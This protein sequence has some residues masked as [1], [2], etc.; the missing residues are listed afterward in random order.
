MSTK[1]RLDFIDLHKGIVLLIMIEVHVFNSLLLTGIKDA[2]WF[3]VINFINGLVAPSFIFVSGFAFSLSNSQKIA[4]LK[5]FRKT[6]GKYISRLLLIFAAGYSLHLP[7]FS[8]KKTIYESTPEQIQAFLAVD[9]LQS[10]AVGLF[11]LFLIRIIFENP[12]A[13]K[14]ALFSLIIIVLTLSVVFWNTEITSSLPLF[15]SNYLTNINGSQ[16]PL[17]PWFAFM[18]AGYISGI[19]FVETRNSGKVETYFKVVYILAGLFIVNGHLGIWDN[20][21]LY[22]PL[23]RPNFF[24]FILRLGYIFLLFNLCR[25]LTSKINLQNSFILNISRASLLVY[26]LHLI[27]MFGMFWNGESLVFI[28]GNTLTLMEAIGATIILI[29]LMVTIAN[30]WTKLK[31]KNPELSGKITFSFALLIALIYIIR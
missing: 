13:L 25:T 5:K 6:F 15:L 3:S 28:I 14:I 16:F 22:I 27:L 9:V 7:F 4:E 19:Y 24:F 17:F 30:Y 31:I 11:L 2:S 20:F 21:F 8:L 26:W 12:K 29:L 18:L 23:P 10:I 1:Q